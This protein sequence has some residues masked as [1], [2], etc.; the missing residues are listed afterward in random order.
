[1]EKCQESDSPTCWPASRPDV[2][3]Q[4][5]FTARRPQAPRMGRSS[6]RL[7]SQCCLTEECSHAGACLHDTHIYSLHRKM[8]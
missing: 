8:V 7:A 5:R 3:R 6:G 2:S 4:R 1:M